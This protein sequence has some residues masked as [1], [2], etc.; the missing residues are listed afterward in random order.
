MVTHQLQV[1]CRPVKVRRSESTDDVLPLSH[2][3]NWCRISVAGCPFFYSTAGVWHHCT[4]IHSSSLPCFSCSPESSKPSVVNMFEPSRC[5][6]AF[7]SR[8][9][10]LGH[11]ACGLHPDFQQ[12]LHQSWWKTSPASLA[13][14]SSPASSSFPATW[15]TL[16]PPWSLTQPP[17][18]YS[19]IQ[20]N[21]QL[22]FNSYVIKWHNF[23]LCIF[24][25]TILYFC[26]LKRG[27]YDLILLKYTVNQKKGGSTFVIITLEKLHRFL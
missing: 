15:T 10:T 13:P 8:S 12:H 19:H 3:T 24:T 1:R 16:V 20:L 4:L 23:Y 14:S 25:M 2:P 21:R 9:A 27:L 26:I 17:A 22:L 6:E 11:R 7:M 5:L 18:S